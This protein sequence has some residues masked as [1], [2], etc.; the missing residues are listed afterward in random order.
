[1]N[2]GSTKLISASTFPIGFVF[3]PTGKMK[4]PIS[5]AIFPT[6]KMKIPNKVELNLINPI[7]S[8]P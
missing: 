1:M 6:R 4:N 5:S 7:W 2:G 3:K 8:M